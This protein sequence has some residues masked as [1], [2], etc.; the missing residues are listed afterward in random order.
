MQDQPFEGRD[1]TIESQDIIGSQITPCSVAL[2]TKWLRHDQVTTFRSSSD[3]KCEEIEFWFSWTAMFHSIML[4]IPLFSK[5]CIVIMGQTTTFHAKLIRSSA[6]HPNRPYFFEMGL[7]ILSKIDLDI[8]FFENFWII[9]KKAKKMLV[10]LRNF[11][12]IFAH[13]ERN[14]TSFVCNL[15]VI[16]TYFGRFMDIHVPRTVFHVLLHISRFV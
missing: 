9:P 1:D 13:L 6:E 2:Y 16:R 11:D 5:I 3:K 8:C 7:T 14:W 4:L 15:N 12:V 10:F